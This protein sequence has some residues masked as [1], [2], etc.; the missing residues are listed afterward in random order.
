MKRF[1]RSLLVATLPALL[2][3]G[4][5]SAAEVED[6]VK[7]RKANMK[8]IGGAMGMMAAIVKGKVDFQDALADNARALHSLTLHIEDGFPEGSMHEDSR[9]KPEIWQKWDK[10][11]NAAGNAREAAA[12][13]VTAAESGNDVGG[14]FKKLGAAC[15][16][17]HKPFR[18]K[19]D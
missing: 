14:A 1:K 18:V 11:T 6:V 7:Y 17:C 4:S 15:G 2:I 9:A 8:G 5:L 12:A 16:K 13:M 10:F 19:K 3:A